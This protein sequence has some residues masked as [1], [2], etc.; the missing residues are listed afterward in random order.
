MIRLVLL[1]SQFII[2]ILKK[3]IGVNITHSGE[4]PSKGSVL[5]LSNH[6]T[7]F[8]TFIVPYILFSEYDHVG[9]SLGDD[10]VFVGWLGKYM[11]LAGTISIKNKIKNRII[12][13]DLISG[14]A[15]WIIYP[16]G[17]M[18]KN[19]LITFNDGEF[20]INTKS[21]IKPIYT[22]AAV[23]ALKAEIL[24]DR[25]KNRDNDTHV[26][27]VP[28][29]ITYNHIRP[30]E[31]KLL[32]W[33]DKY[34]NV[35][36]THFFEELEIEINL[37][38]KSNMHLHFAKPICVSKYVNKFL[39][40]HQGALENDEAMDE[41]IGKQRKV[42]ITDV[43]KK[44]YDNTQINFDHIFILSLVTMP[45]IKVCPSYLKT[46]IYKN[47]RS[48]E[49][50]RN[51]NMHS[52]LKDELFALILDSKY[53][54]FLS[55]IKLAQLQHIL[56]EDSEGDYLF[57]RNLL[58]KEYDFD[59]V[60][61]KNTLQVILNEIKLQKNI[62]DMAYKN[63][64]FSQKELER[65][66]FYYLREKEYTTFEKEYISY[67][68]TLPSE[69][70]TS[71][72]IVLYDENNSHGLVF[73]HGYMA[74]PEEARQ[75]AQYLFARGINVYLPRLRGHGTDPVALKH[76]ASSDWEYDFKLAITAMS[77]VCDKVFIG[78]FATGGLLALLHAS[79]HKVDGIIVINSAL[80][81]N[82][83]H[84][85][86]VVPTLHVFN[87]M[88][89]SLNEKGI[90][91]WVENKSENP[92]ISYSK[93]PLNSIAQMEK[94]MTKADSILTQIKDP[95]L[96]IQGDNDPIVNPKSAQFIYKGVKSKV[97]KLVLLPRDNHSIIL[98]TG[99]EE[100]FESIYHFISRL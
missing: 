85:S 55:S 24:R 71:A 98:G 67:H 18:I 10:S 26:Q 46:L 79:T 51:L 34:L 95:I 92:N 70:N 80:R 72:P 11:E 42:L 82:S 89:S 17:N 31:N 47:A 37:L 60:R 45:T 86:Y 56:Y 20:Y 27:I 66:N 3:L 91:E 40:E 36:G 54:P 96:V 100:I 8:E 21:G 99:E 73:S 16:E 29:S 15:D 94:L 93:H 28:L 59:K 39:E 78:G 2:F 13:N 5:I 9:R 90:V 49:K 63:A 84:V 53:A 44:V 19:K 4:L 35:R 64:A 83:L 76:I 38:M 43:M 41:Y 62:V 23:L 97:K 7:R 1:I 57:D 69:D 75:L 22:G 68:K 25:I 52:E 30:G 61:V 88:I 81:L 87:E 65:D 74:T 58:E 48:L 33:I 50:I 12:L 6:F 77:Q 32:L 14:E